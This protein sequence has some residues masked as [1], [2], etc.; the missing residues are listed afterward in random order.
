MGIGYFVSS[1]HIDYELTITKRGDKTLNIDDW[2][3]FQY[4]AET[5]NGLANNFT[6]IKS[7]DDILNDLDRL[8]KLR[9]PQD[10]PTRG[11]F[12]QYWNEIRFGHFLQVPPD[13]D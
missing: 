3:I 11:P 6:K 1:I 13:D 2:R 7:E 4:Y 5:D 10:D 9:A 12:V 8:F